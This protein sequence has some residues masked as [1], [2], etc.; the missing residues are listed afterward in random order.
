MKFLDSVFEVCHSLKQ[1]NL[2][3]SV[4]SIGKWCFSQCKSLTKI[5]FIRDNAFYISSLEQITIPSL[6]TS[7]NE[8][9]F[10]QCFHHS[11]MT[12]EN[13]SSINTMKK[14]AFKYCEN[15]KDLVL[16]NSLVSIESGAFRKCLLLTQI[17]FPS[18]VESIGNVSF[19]E[20]KIL[21][22][23]TFKEYLYWSSC[24]FRVF[25]ID[26]NINSFFFGFI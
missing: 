10:E 17:S 25:F 18:S 4:T 2:P 3:S 1:I 23:V 12:F 19:T 8:G 20:C 21:G 16:P 5:E 11:R 15:L 7:I 13:P 24:F 9:T 26:S 22:Q 6:I 14:D